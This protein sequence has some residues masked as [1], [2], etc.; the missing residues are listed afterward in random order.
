[1]PPWLR[2]AAFGQKPAETTA[3]RAVSAFE[4]RQEAKDARLTEEPRPLRGGIH[5]LPKRSG[6]RFPSFRKGVR[7]A[8]CTTLGGTLQA[9]AKKSGAPPLAHQ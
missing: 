8:A 9:A 6:I 5:R 3:S 7:E 4:K 1:V 2:F